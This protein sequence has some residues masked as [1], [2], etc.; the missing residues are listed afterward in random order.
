[1]AEK[2]FYTLAVHA[3]E[4]L[5]LNHGSVSVPIYNSSVYAFPDADEGA[6]IHNNLKEGYFYGKYGIRRRTL[7]KKLSANWKTANRRSL[8]RPVRKKL[9]T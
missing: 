5:S 3:G 2:S 6:A 7:W 4:D 1:M 8:S 9:M